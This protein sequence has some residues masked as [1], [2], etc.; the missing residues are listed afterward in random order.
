MLCYTYV[1][2]QLCHI[3][4]KNP[5]EINVLTQTILLSLL[6]RAMLVHGY[7]PS[8]LLKSTIVPVLWQDSITI[9]KP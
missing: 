9:F 7:Y 1:N 8:E 6:F 2:I 5:T 3:H 4:K